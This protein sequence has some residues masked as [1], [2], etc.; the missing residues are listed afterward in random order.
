MANLSDAFGTIEVKSIGAEFIE[1]LNTVQNKDTYYSLVELIDIDKEPDEHGN[2]SFN[3]STSGRWDYGSNLEGYLQGK[4]MVKT[5]EK[6]AYQKFISALKRKDGSVTVTYTD[7]DRSND[8]MGTGVAELSIINNKVNFTDTF[9]DEHITIS[10][11]AELC[12]YDDYEALELLHGDDIAS[13]YSKYI[14]EWDHIES[15]GIAPL[16]PDDWYKYEYEA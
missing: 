14:K 5:K 4:W 10:G 12:G 15:E 13:Q 11:Y 3:F 1:F 9:N 16:G 7:S 6:R 8:W 2:L